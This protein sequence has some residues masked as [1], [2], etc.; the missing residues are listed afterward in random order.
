MRPI[1]SLKSWRVVRVVLVS[2][3]VLVMGSQGA[4]RAGAVTRTWDTTTGDWF[5]GTNWNPV[6]APAAGDDLIVNA[7]GEPAAGVPVTSTGSI[8]INSGADAVFNAGLNVFGGTLN[9]NG[10]TIT[11]GGGLFVVPSTDYF[12]SGAGGPNL[13]LNNGGGLNL[14]TFALTVGDMADGSLTINDGS[15]VTNGIGAIGRFVG[16]TG[17]VTVNNGGV[18]NNSGTIRVGVVDGIG[19]MTVNAGGSVSS[20]TG[21]VAAFVGSTGT[22]NLNGSWTSG[23]LAVGGGARGFGRDRGAERQ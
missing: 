23:D 13:I 16:S 18:W 4:R 7:A 22:V 11:V 19:I 21:S 17:T 20:A 5:V 10:G 1:E 9:H 6:G 2:G 3:C 12:I 8:T 14:G 15:T